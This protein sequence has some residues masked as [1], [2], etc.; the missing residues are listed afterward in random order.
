MGGPKIFVIGFH[1]TATS[2]LASALTTLGFRVAVPHGV[3]DKDIGH[4]VLASSL[5]LVPHYDAFQDNPWPILYREMD[6]RWPGSRFILTVRSTDEWISSVVKHFGA[7]STPMREWIYGVGAPRGNEGIYVRRY[8]EH[9]RAVLEHFRDRPA[10][11]LVLDVTNGDG[12]EPL[13]RFVDRGVP[14]V[15]FPHANPARRRPRRP[16]T[17]RRIPA[18]AVR[19][20]HSLVQRG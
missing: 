20:I 14:D 4:H 11:L 8:E 17:W 3:H 2:S 13:C 7:T 5:E 9:N 19:R 10:D 1:K 6:D 12:W 16:G 18:K 15:P